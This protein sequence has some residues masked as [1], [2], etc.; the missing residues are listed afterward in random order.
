VFIELA[1]ITCTELFQLIINQTSAM[2]CDILTSR[3]SICI[4]CAHHLV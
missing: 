3:K 4:F 2:D 1:R